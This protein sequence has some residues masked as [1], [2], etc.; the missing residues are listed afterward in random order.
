[1]CVAPA[2]LLVAMIRGTIL[3]ACWQIAAAVHMI[4][5]GWKQDCLKKLND[6]DMEADFAYVGAGGNAFVLQYKGKDLK[7][8]GGK[9]KQIYYCMYQGAIVKVYDDLNKAAASQTVNFFTDEKP[10]GRSQKPILKLLAKCGAAAMPDYCMGNQDLCM[11]QKKCAHKKDAPK[12]LIQ[13]DF[14]SEMCWYVVLLPGGEK[15]LEQCFDKAKEP[16]KKEDFLRL[17][18][19]AT[20]I[21][22]CL[23]DEELVH[24][25]FQ[26]KNIMTN[27][28]TPSKVS[29]PPITLTVKAV[30]L[31][32]VRYAPDENQ[33]YYLQGS[34]RAYRQD[35]RILI[36][37]ENSGGD[38]LTKYKQIASNTWETKG[39]ADEIM[40]WSKVNLPSSPEDGKWTWDDIKKK[41]K[42]FREKLS[43]MKK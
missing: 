42:M 35:L 18:Q 10:V 37:A 28:C 38:S 29:K 39:A 8:L 30:D 16:V 1:M 22:Q 32:G 43:E 21:S 12:K 14:P 13:S 2:A 26:L 4:S 41:E 25:D 20:E 6:V 17:L 15:T 7:A 23:H 5:S 33:E 27:D 31:D 9:S 40:E 24:G 34:W 3:V 19:K 36:G 11:F